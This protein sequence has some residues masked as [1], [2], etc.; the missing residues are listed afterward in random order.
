[1]EIFSI[2]LKSIRN[3]NI[4]LAT[5]EVG[6]FVLHGDLIV[7]YGIV[8][9]ANDDEKF[10][11]ALKESQHLIALEMANKYIS[12]SIKTEKQLKDYLY[13]KEFKKQTIET[14][15]SKLKEYN[16][17]DDKNFAK[18]YIQSNPNF[19]R[20][21]IKQKLF[22]FGVKLEDFEELLMRV[23]D[24]EGCKKNANKFLKGKNIDKALYEKLVRRLLGQGYTYETI[25]NVLSELKMEIEED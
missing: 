22:S 6:D 8:G 16:I 25:K 13:K 20:N 17:I 3:S 15:I 19:S 5:T 1:M 10:E 21:K 23:E 14:V 12:C 4:F 11:K 24:F 9:G 18:L 7:K 2:R